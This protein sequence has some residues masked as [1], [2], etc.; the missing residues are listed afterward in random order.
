MRQTILTLAIAVLALGACTATPDGVVQDFFAAVDS[1]DVERL[2][3]VIDF[4]ALRENLK[5]DFRAQMAEEA[6]ELG[7]GLIADIGTA[8][9][10]SLVDAMIDNLF[11]SETLAR[12]VRNGDSELERSD[13]TTEQIAPD[14]FDA[15]FTGDGD[16]EM[17]F[18]FRKK[19]GQWKLFRL[20]LPDL[21]KFTDGKEAH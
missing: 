13:Y 9:V 8:L 16:E 14:R 2:E 19:D 10:D 5:T 20:A 7:T 18:Q 1:G 15:V 4:P 17:R 21:G 3:E 6:A 11:T 12:A